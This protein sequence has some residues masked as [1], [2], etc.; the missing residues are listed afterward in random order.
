MAKVAAKKVAE[1]AQSQMKQQGRRRGHKKGIR[2]QG[3]ADAGCE[4]IFSFGFIG[5]EVTNRS[6][7]R[8]QSEKL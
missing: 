5:G 7:A 1:A 2:L 8:G 3:R 6:R 4:L